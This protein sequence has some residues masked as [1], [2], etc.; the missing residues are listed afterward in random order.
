MEEEDSAFESA[1]TAARERGDE[2][3]VARLHK[4]R[5]KK[6]RPSAVDDNAAAIR[7][8]FD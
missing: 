5:A 8:M 2:D 6:W 1:I 7:A 4:E 3:E